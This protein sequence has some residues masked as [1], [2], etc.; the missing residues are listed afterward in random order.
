MYDYSKGART[1][2]KQ[3]LPVLTKAKMLYRETDWKLVRR[4]TR[5]LHVFYN[6]CFLFFFLIY[7]HVKIL[8]I[9][10]VFY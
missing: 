5:K 4:N 6:I 3:E 8:H 2:K 10:L 1:V 7:Y 9:V